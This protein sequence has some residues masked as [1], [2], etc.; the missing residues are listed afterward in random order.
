[1]AETKV[2]ERLISGT[3]VLRMP[4]GESSV[5]Y[6]SVLVNVVREPSDINRSFAYNPFRQR[7]ATMV[8]LRDGLVIFEEAIN[9]SARRFDYLVSEAGQNLIALKCVSKQL[10]GNLQSLGAPGG[11]SNIKEFADLS[12]LWTELRFV[13][14]ADTAIQVR[15]FEDHYDDCGDEYHQK[16]PPPPPPPLPPVPPRTPIG[17][18]SPPYDSGDDITSPFP[19]DS[20]PPPEGG[21]TGSTQTGNI[22]QVAYH[23]RQFPGGDLLTRGGILV[24]GKVGDQLRFKPDGSKIVQIYAQGRVTNPADPP[25]PAPLG[26]VDLQD[27]DDRSVDLSLISVTPYP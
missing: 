17:D 25:A 15:L 12:F 13:C 22:Y 4:P 9:Y 11:A 23:V 20:S 1:M 6:Y 21:D 27:E 24:L 7:F 18:I 14:Y 5:R 10:L 2:A 19:G 16:N 8:G 3:G 26:W